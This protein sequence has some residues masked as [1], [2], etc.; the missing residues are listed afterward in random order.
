[1]V[2]HFDKSLCK[3]ERVDDHK[4]IVKVKR[5]L[6][7]VG[8]YI[9]EGVE[10]H[11]VGVLVVSVLLLLLCYIYCYF[12]CLLYVTYCSVELKCPLRLF[13]NV[14]GFSHQIVHQLMCQSFDL[15]FAYH[16]YHFWNF[17]FPLSDK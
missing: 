6:Q 11:I 8:L 7:I 13:W 15:Y 2:S 4:F 10:K 14:V 9:F 5:D 1:M 3:L 17:L 16:L 12:N